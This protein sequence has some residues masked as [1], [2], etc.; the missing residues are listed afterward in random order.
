[1]ADRYVS[2]PTTLSDL[3]GRDAKG[4]TFLDDLKCANRLTSSDQIRYG[5]TCGEGR[6]S[7]GGGR[8][9]ILIERAQHPNL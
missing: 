3:E 7:S 1:V 4:Q 2:V 5:N 8:H 9:P 6:V